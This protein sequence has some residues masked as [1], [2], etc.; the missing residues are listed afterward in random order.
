MSDLHPAAACRTL[1][2]TP[3]FESLIAWFVMTFLLGPI[4]SQVT[5]QLQA[6]RAPAAVMAQVGACAAAATPGLVQRAADDPWWAIRTGIGAWTG[7]IGTEGL[8]RVAGPSC[9]PA[10]EA[11]RPYLARG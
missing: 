11:A 1:E 9:A 10:L 4:Q 3:M 8:L 7:Q 6:A 2:A 5:E